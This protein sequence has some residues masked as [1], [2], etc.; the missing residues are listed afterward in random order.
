M[1]PKLSTLWLK[2]L[3]R[4]EDKKELRELI[5]A[6]SRVLERLNEIVEEKEY[7]IVNEMRLKTNFKDTSW[8]HYTASLLGELRFANYIKDLIKGAIISD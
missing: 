1:T 3:E 5:L 7:S 6:S 8:S 4:D 2:D